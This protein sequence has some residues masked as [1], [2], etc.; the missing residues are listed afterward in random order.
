[1]KR[2]DFIKGTAAGLVAGTTL[3]LSDLI[4]SID[5]APKP[6]TAPI[7]PGT[8]P[9]GTRIVIDGKE[10]TA[11][12]MQICNERDVTTTT[13]LN[14]YPNHS[15]SLPEYSTL[16]MEI[17]CQDDFLQRAYAEHRVLPCQVFLGLDE[18]EFEAMIT[19]CITSMQVDD[20]L[21]QTVQFRVIGNILVSQRA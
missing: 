20:E 17:Y 16:E 6:K 5:A 14:P 8:K 4:A 21:T 12:S 3:T 18:I 9:Q 15:V 2:R 19:Q 10:I 11:I 1:M 13:E 7:P